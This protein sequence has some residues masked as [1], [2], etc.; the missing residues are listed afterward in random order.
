[1]SCEWTF[2]PT[3]LGLK[4]G[5]QT[6]NSLQGLNPEDLQSIV[7]AHSKTLNSKEKKLP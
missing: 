6:H 3:N 2:D 5:S 1:V 7:R 4:R